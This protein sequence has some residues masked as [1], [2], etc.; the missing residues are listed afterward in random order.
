MSESPWTKHMHAMTGLLGYMAGFLG[1]TGDPRTTRIEELRK[2]LTSHES[3]CRYA[4]ID[5]EVYTRIL[6]N[7]GPDCERSVLRDLKMSVRVSQERLT[8]HTAAAHDLAIEIETLSN[9][10]ASEKKEREARQ[11]RDREEIAARIR[12]EEESE[13]RTREGD[14]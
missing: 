5:V 8:I 2:L 12:K 6:A 1:F 14:V 4:A 3:A 13:A 7:P 9:Q 11:A 10:L